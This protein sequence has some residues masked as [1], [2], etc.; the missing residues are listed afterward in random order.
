MG[1]SEWVKANPPNALKGKRGKGGGS[2][3]IM[4]FY[5]IKESNYIFKKAPGI[6]LCILKITDDT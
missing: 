3:V 6:G 5:T 2:N 4:M 1:A